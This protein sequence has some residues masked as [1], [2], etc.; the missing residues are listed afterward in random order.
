[1]VINLAIKKTREIQLRIKL[2]KEWG[3]HLLVN[4]SSSKYKNYCTLQVEFTY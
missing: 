4:I 2:N 3:R 1:M